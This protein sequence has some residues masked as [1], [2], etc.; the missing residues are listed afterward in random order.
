LNIFLDNINIDALSDVHTVLNRK[1]EHEISL[2]TLSEH[3]VFYHSKSDRKIIPTHVRNI[4]DVSGAGD[5]VIA[6]ASLAYA[7]TKDIQLAA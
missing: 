4:A 7:S 5:T 2:I 3:G 6:V 1:I